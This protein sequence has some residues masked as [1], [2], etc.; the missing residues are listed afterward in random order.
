MAAVLDGLALHAALHPERLGPDTM[1]AVLRRH[2]AQ[3]PGAR[4]DG[5]PGP[6]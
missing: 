4:P 1:L 2:L 6:G 3:L 5:R